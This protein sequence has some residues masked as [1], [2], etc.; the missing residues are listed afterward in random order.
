MWGNVKSFPTQN[1]HKMT[2]K[3]Q[4]QR[5]TDIAREKGCI[6]TTLTDDELQQFKDAVAPMYDSFLNEE[7]AAIVARVQA[8]G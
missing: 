4:I 8:L 6:L 3:E 7:Q 5:I 2:A 1:P